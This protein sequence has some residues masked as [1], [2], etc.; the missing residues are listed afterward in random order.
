[1]LMTPFIKMGSIDWPK[2]QAYY[3]DLGECPVWSLATQ[4]VQRSLVS[5]VC[6]LWPCGQITCISFFSLGGTTLCPNGPGSP[7]AYLWTQGPPCLLHPKFHVAVYQQFCETFTVTEQR[8][9]QILTFCRCVGGSLK[10]VSYSK[11]GG[12]AI[13]LRCRLMTSLT[14][15]WCI[16][17]QGC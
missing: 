6:L 2:K 14:L 4:I 9:S 1:M 11:A 3:K 17:Q 7:S 15:G 5:K 16:A 8:N 10:Q 13:G 12:S